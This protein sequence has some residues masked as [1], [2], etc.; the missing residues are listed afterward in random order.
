MKNEKPIGRSATGPK[1]NTGKARSSKNAVK[2][3]LTAAT[4]ILKHECQNDLN[5]LRAGLRASLCPVGHL[6]DL[7]A[8]RIVQ[9]AW[10]LRRFSKVETETMQH[11][12]L[13]NDFDMMFSP[14]RITD[15]VRVGRG[16][17]RDVPLEKISRYETASER[18]FFRC[19]Q[20]FWALQARRQKATKTLH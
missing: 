4:T 1:S 2:H 18:S 7:V 3:G 8:E 19:L 15:G 6:E 13:D 20:E 12:M 14:G 17:G 5:A 10:R 11:A 16:I 9:H